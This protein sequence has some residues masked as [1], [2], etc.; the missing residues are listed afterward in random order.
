M[1][2]KE[3]ASGTSEFCHMMDTFFDC[4]NVRNYTSG[5]HNR[6]PFQ[7]PYRSPDDERLKV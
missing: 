7:M 2:M 1:T 4:L 6:K 3:E 5:I